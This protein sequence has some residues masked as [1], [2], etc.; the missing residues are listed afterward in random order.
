MNYKYWIAFLMMLVNGVFVEAQK[1]DSPTLVKFKIIDATTAKVTPAMICLMDLKDSSIHTPTLKSVVG[2][3]SKISDFYK[4]IEFSS[5][6]IREFHCMIFQRA[7][8]IVHRYGYYF[9]KV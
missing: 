9:I 3:L 6:K 4:G 1:A 2:S 5:L 8:K 7:K